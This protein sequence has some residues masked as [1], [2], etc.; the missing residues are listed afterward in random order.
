MKMLVSEPDKTTDPSY[1]ETSIW[2]AIKSGMVAQTLATI[3]SG[4][5]DD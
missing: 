5:Y 3:E 2:Y 1:L 4:F